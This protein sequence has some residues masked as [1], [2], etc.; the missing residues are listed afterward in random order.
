MINLALERTYEKI[1]Q[2]V[3]PRDGIILGGTW[4]HD[5]W[6]LTSNPET[7]NRDTSGVC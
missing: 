2:K 1:V 3:A 5:D 6:S 7:D 4:D